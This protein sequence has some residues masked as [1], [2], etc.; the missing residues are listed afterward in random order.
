MTR[1]QIHRHGVIKSLPLLFAIL[2]TIYSQ[3]NSRGITFRELEEPRIPRTY[4]PNNPAETC[5][6]ILYSSDANGDGKVNHDEYVSFVGQLSEGEVEVTN[7]ID[8]PFVIKINFVYLSCLCMYSPKNEGSECCEGT[9]AGIYVSGAG[10][11][12]TP[13]VTEG[14][15]LTTVCSETQGAIDFETDEASSSPTDT[16]ATSP[17]SV[18]SGSPST[19]PTM[20]VSYIIPLLRCRK[21][22]SSAHNRGPFFQPTTLTPTQS[23]SAELTESVSSS[24]LVAIGAHSSAETDPSLPVP[25]F[26]ITT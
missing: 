25:Y 8:L 26:I 17:T 7:Y 10:P 1:I 13:T 9:D 18:P 20:R 19:E 14:Q 2:P 22:D 15:Y 11:N 23:P 3:P 12:D 24:E 21:N 6:E 16:V 4:D 5:Y